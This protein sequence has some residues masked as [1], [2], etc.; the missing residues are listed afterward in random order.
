MKNFVIS[1][2]ENND[3]RRAHIINEFSQ[4]KVPFEFFDAITPRDNEFL[5]QKY[6]LDKID[7]ELSSVEISC[8]L[9]HYQLWQHMLEEELPFIGVFEDDIYLGEDADL[10]LNNTDWL[11]PDIH[12]LKLEKGWQKEVRTSFFAKKTINKRFI[13][14]LSSPHYGTAGY[15]LSNMGARYLIEQYRNIKELK[16]IDV[17]M[18]RILLDDSNYKVDQLSPAICIQDFLINKDAE[19]FHSLIEGARQDKNKG[20]VIKEKKALLFKVRREI[21]RPILQISQFIKKPSMRR[22]VSFK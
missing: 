20:T 11:S 16:P 6:G 14:Q 2:S 18:F 22:I 15:I 12:V 19:N 8:F 3:K 5:L 17:F 9:S 7:T 21:F 1:L 13:F 10:F 4:K